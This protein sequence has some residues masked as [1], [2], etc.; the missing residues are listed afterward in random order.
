MR[1]GSFPVPRSTQAAT[2]LGALRREAE[3]LAKERNERLT[4]THVLYALATRE[5]LPG[6]LLA[7]RRISR[8][9]LLKA[10]RIA[11]DDDH[12]KTPP[13]D[14]LFAHARE[15]A[16]RT[17]MPSRASTEVEGTHVLLAICLE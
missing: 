10:L 13:L 17:R 15:L 9:T 2:D 16:S 1:A 4:T 8:E 3:G 7:E 11:V 14:R 12:D 5:G 6:E